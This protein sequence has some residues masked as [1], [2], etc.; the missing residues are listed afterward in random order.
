MAEPPHGDGR[1][2]ANIHLRMEQH[3]W[4][5]GDRVMLKSLKTEGT[6][7]ADAAADE[8]YEKLIGWRGTIVQSPSEAGLFASFSEEPRLLIQFDQSVTEM[9]LHC[10][11][12][13][14]NSLWILESDLVALPSPTRAE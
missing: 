5:R 6:A 8:N 11:N 7:R 2:V 12:D 1:R 10:H 9:K 13:V 14:P 3:M 4:R